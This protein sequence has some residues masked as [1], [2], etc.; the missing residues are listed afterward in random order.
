MYSIK[1]MCMEKEMKK[2]NIIQ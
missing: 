1:S 2:S